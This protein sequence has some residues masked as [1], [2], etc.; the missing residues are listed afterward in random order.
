MFYDNVKDLCALNRINVTQLAKEL[1][2]STSMPTKWK[3]GAVP[4]AS[5]LKKIA[6]YFGVSTD[7][8]LTEF[9]PSFTIGNI[10]NSTVLQGTG[11]THHACQQLSSEESELLRIYRNLP[12]RSRLDL[13]RTAFEME[14]KERS[15]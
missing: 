6:D 12:I 2:L 7:D 4:K 5:T 11:N 15:Q 10:S 13:M 3:N 1:G 8:L 9:G 14:D